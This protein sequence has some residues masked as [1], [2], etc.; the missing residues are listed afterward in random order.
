MNSEEEIKIIWKNKIKPEIKKVDFK[1][2]ETSYIENSTNSPDN[3]LF[4]GDN[5]EVLFFLLENFREKI[6]LIYIDPPFATGEA[7]KHK[8]KVSDGSWT[9]VD[10]FFEKKA[11]D[12]T[13][14]KNLSIYL[15]MLYER[16]C[17][18]KDLL[19]KRGSI[20]VHVDWRVSG[21]VKLI[22]E[23]IFGKYNF[24]NEII[25][26]YVT[27]G[28]PKDRFAKKHDTIFWYAKNAGEHIFNLDDVRTPYDEERKKKATLDDDGNLVYVHGPG[29]GVTK[30]HPKG[31]ITDDVWKIALVNSMAKERTTYPTQKPLELIERITKA[32]SN[33]NSLIADFFLGSGTT[34]IAAEKLKRRW[35]GVD[36]SFFALNTA[37]KRLLKKKTPFHIF[38]KSTFKES[39]IPLKNIE[40]N[41]D[42][43]LDGELLK[44]TFKDY[45][46]E[47]LINILKEKMT[48]IK[49]PDDL[50]DFWA[51]DFD[52]RN[53]FN[54]NWC[55]FKTRNNNFINLECSHR[56]KELG[57][58]IIKIQFIDIFNNYFESEMEIFI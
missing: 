48:E 22:L 3:L 58:K 41:F 16:L 35:I 10:N 26:N 31:R 44:I 52:F 47:K 13:W 57:K 11:Y 15:Q 36:N 54:I 21:Y 55:S 18:M 5:K 42:V 53:V 6:D 8:I 49:I 30:L 23:E 24:L 43:H 34:C 27:P 40:W 2:I 9:L 7:F 17:L 4:Y 25:W 14:G 39:Q 50:I 46:N 19:S 1:L 37:K 28:Y 45:Q 56:Y 33:P 12:D 32:A 20:F 29:F 51:V 38:S